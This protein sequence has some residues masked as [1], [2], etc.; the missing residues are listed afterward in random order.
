MI[1]NMALLFRNNAT[2]PMALP[3]G[4]RQALTS[5][6]N[7]SVAPWTVHLRSPTITASGLY[8]AG[9]DGHWLGPEEEFQLPLPAR[10]ADR[11]EASVFAPSSLDIASN[12]CCEGDGA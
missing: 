5:V 10:S 8:T 6:V 9:R 1:V 4:D 7:F 2:L 3:V 12:E 11:V